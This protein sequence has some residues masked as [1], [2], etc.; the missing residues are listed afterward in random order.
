MWIGLAVYSTSTGWTGRIPALM[1]VLF[2]TNRFPG[3][4]MR[5]DQQRALQQLRHL[6]RRHAITLLSFEAAQDDDPVA[7]EVASLCERVVVRTESALVRMARGTLGLFGSRPLQSAMYDSPARR[8]VVDELLAATPFDL[9][10][11]QLARLGGL[12]EHLEARRCVIDLVD[13]LSLNMARRAEFDRT[14]LR[15]LASFEA[16][17]M[18]RYERALCTRATRVSIC[19][20]MDRTAIG[21]FANLR[22]V[23]NGV[24][25][26]EFPFDA[27]ARR[28]EDIVFVGNL[29]YFPN[30]DAVQWF[31]TEVLPTL[32]EHRPALRLR[33]VGARP[34]VAIRN[35]AQ[36]IPGI[37]LVGPVPD[38]CAYL[39][40][41]AIAI[42]PLRAGSGQQLKVIEAMAAGT[43]VVATTTAAA[44]LDAIDGT[45]WRVAPDA[46]TMAH[47]ILELL[48][49]PSQGQT[50]ARAARAFV[51][52]RHTW[53]ASAEAL[54][55]LWFEA[56][57]SL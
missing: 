3:L 47:A 7:R 28:R 38:V 12:V 24:D 41:A 44:G 50:M 37:E 27:S 9:V 36:R 17:R 5:G 25:L 4:A 49:E 23:D 18:A 53:R 2:V 52:Q 1:R 56:A 32:R 13:A 35:L 43:P 8:R 45:H 40:R 55:Q 14:P 54:E 57:A 6:G 48:R 20:P 11:V 51:E 29:G 21:D 15:W 33:L 30:I 46:T 26:A 39:H 34:A 42:A 22:R 16:S 10:H 19:S 31:A